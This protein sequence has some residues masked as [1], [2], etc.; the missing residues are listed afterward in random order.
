MVDKSS[1]N[2]KLKLRV[3][4]TATLKPSWRQIAELQEMGLGDRFIT[5]AAGIEVELKDASLINGHQYVVLANSYKE[6]DRGFF[7][8]PSV[9]IIDGNIK[10]AEANIPLPEYPNWDLGMDFASR[11]IRYMM[12]KKYRIADGY[13]ERNIVYLEGVNPDGLVNSDRLDEWNDI[14]CIVSFDKNKPYFAMAPVTA[15]TEPGAH[16]TWNPMNEKGAFRIAFGQYAAWQIG[17]HGHDWGLAL[18]QTGDITGHRDLN[19]DGQRTGDKTDT[20]S[21]FYVNQHRSYS[22]GNVGISSAGCFV[23]EHVEDHWRFMDLVM[24]DPRYLRDR[25][26]TFD[27]TVIDGDDFSKSKWGYR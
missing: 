21:D 8:A 20:G 13:R 24:K 25:S 2:P 7:W 22:H 4:T 26:F 9:E 1:A 19:K 17:R 11:I 27:T 18:V 23:R 15:T 10:A 5:F 6:S 3:K 16:Y 14:C 12:D